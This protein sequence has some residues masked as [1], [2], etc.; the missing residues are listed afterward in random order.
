MA[1]VSIQAIKELRERTSAGMT[2]C[3]KA[4]TEAEGDMEKA[5]ELILKRGQ[6]KSAK[7]AGKVAAEGEVRTK[8]LNDGKAA[9]VVEV[10]IETD[11][12]A[13]NEKFQ[14]LLDRT[15]AAAAEAPEGAELAKLESDGKTLEEHATEL[16]GVIGEKITLRRYAKLT[17]A[18]S[19]LCHDYV[20]M[21]GRIG[22]I[23]SLETS[24][25]AVAGHEAIKTFAEDT[26]LQIAAMNP[27]YLS[28]A[29]VDEAAVAKQKE[30]FEAQLREDP[31]PKPEK[32]WP[33]IIE[34]KVN[35]WFKETVLIDQ[36]SAQHAK[37]TIDGLRKEAGKA[38][39][40]EVKITGFHRFEL[41]E[42]I[43]K[44]EENFAADVAEL[45]EQ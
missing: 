37:K 36:D 39:G 29:D 31:K 16:T 24:N 22:V 25:D 32:V 2:D 40:G 41:G 17:V 6:A 18:E 27:Q 21:G 33:K 38:A 45:L 28:R 42:G 8:L 9:I 12:S 13:R 20:H 7:R 1:S 30:I 15:V 43:E 3:K 4:L 23:L 14:A 44:K 19:G 11:F 10:N 35:A 26:A 5:V 34:G